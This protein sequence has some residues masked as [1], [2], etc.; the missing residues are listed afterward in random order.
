MY[1]AHLVEVFR[2]VRRVLRADGCLW[3]VLGDSFATRP[4][5]QPIAENDIKT[6]DLI[7]I[8]WLTAFAL[9]ADGW[10]LRSDIVYS[11]ANPMPE[12]VHDRPT[13]AHE[14]IFLLAKSPHYYYDHAAVREPAVGA[15]HHDLTGMGYT[16][17]GQSPQQGNRKALHGP[18]YAR[19]RSSVPG[20]QDL[21]TAPGAKRN[22]R[23]VWTLPTQPYKEAHFAV[24]PRKLVEPCIL[25]GCPPGGTVLDPFAGSGTTLAVAQQLERT[26]IGI[27]LNPQYLSLI[28]RRVSG[29]PAPTVKPGIMA[30]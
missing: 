1:V 9:R 26:A 21:R 19:H 4:V 30:V 23:S 6:K 13:R 25:A 5:R 2:E 24:F 29:S 3:L 15:N 10:Y 18:T 14:F 8:P 27:E 28:A 17:P 20:G 22:L 11:K 16:A 7:G 12:S